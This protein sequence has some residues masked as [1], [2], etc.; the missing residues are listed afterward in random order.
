MKHYLPK[1]RLVK[2]WLIQAILLA[3]PSFLLA[4]QPD[5][6][7]VQEIIENFARN[8]DAEEFSFDASIDDLENLKKRPLNLNTASA[9]ELSEI[10]LLSAQQIDELQRYIM[11]HGKLISIYELQAVPLWDIATIKT[12]MPYI[13]VNENLQDLHVPLKDLFTKGNTMFLSRYQQQIERSRGYTVPDNLTKQFYQGSPFRLFARFRYTYGTQMS[14][15]FTADKDAGEEFF[16]GS[17]KRGFDFYS[18]HF[19]IRNR[20]QLRALALGDYEVRLGQGLIMWTGFGF[21]KSPAVMMVKRE[22]PKLRPYTSVNEFRFLRGGA[23]TLGFKN[24]E[25]TAFASFKLLDAN[26]VSV[27]AADTAINEDEFFSSILE[28]GLHRTQSEIAKRENIKQLTT[29]GNIAYNKKNWHIG[30]NAVYMRYFTPYVKEQAPYASFDF[31]AQQLLNVSVDYHAVFRNIHFF[32]ENGISNNGGFGLL[33][34]AIISLDKKVDMSVVHRYYSKDF[35]TVYANAFAERSRPQ[36]EH[37]L[38]VGL[39][40]KPIKYLQL[41]G[42]FDL[43]MHPWLKYLVDAPS[44]GNE[45]Y[46]QATVKPNK[47]S[48][49]YVRYRFETKKRNAP[50]NDLPFDYVVNETRQGIRYQHRFRVT[51]ELTISNRVEVSFY[52]VESRK[53]EIGYMFYQDLG[54]KKMGFP[55]SGNARFAIFRTP[56]YNTR[57][58]TYENDVL[59][60]FSIPALYGN[61]IRYYLTLRYSATR[62]LDFWVRWAQTFRSDVKTIGSGLDQVDGNKRSEIKVQMRLRF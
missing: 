26:V 8:E 9:G 19:F 15:G 46:F 61:G 35:Q 16:T 45:N 5:E 21:R 11:R 32:G 6:T 3:L 57:I 50:A 48:E 56:S 4:Q 43:Y 7:E 31:A 28:T 29:G 49:I 42:F 25:A 47:R 60:S 59:Y 14:Y 23:F 13:R 40:V 55:L 12:V 20:K 41:D 53:P 2:S 58:Y 33:N 37:G 51:D 30:A 36:N 22:S 54:Y 10:V 34:G 44:W 24:W 1:K 18:G 62:W 17:N 38:Y 27:A 39:T 52:N